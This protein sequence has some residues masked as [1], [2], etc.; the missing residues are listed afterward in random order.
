MKTKNEKIVKKHGFLLTENILLTHRVC[1][2]VKF[3]NILRHFKRGRLK[4]FA[5]HRKLEN[6]T[7]REA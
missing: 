5:P 1:Q 2:L 4:K 6:V 3:S 7:G